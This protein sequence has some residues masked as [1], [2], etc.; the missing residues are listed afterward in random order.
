MA[1]KLLT[2]SVFSALAGL[3]LSY[4]SYAAVITSTK[5]G[6]GANSAERIHKLNSAWSYNWNMNKTEGL[7]D[8]V[9]YVPM[10]WGKWWPP[11]S[12]VVNS[13]EPEFILGF[14]EPDSAN[15][16]DTSVAVAIT[17]WPNIED[18]AE[19]YDL[20]ICSP[21]TTNYND[22]WMA[23]FMALA[24]DLNYQVDRLC[25]HWYKGPNAGT[26]MNQM[27]WFYNQYGQ[28]PIWL[29][30]F[31]VADWSGPNNYTQG[32]T[33]GFLAEALHRMEASNMIE[34]YAIFPW[35][36]TSTA[37]QASPIFHPNGNEL[38]AI[39]KLYAGFEADDIFGPYHNQI[40]YI[41]H[42]S[43]QRRMTA[44][45]NQVGA[46]NIFYENSDATFK[47]APGAN[48]NWLIENHNGTA[49]L[50][51]DG[52]NIHWTTNLAGTGTWVQ[53][54]LDEGANGWKFIES[55]GHNARL[56]Y[57]GNNFTMVASTATGNTAQWRFIRPD[58]DWQI[59][60]TDTFEGG[61]G[62]NWVDGGTDSMIY[63]GDRSPQGSRSVLLRDDTAS[64]VMT[65]SRMWLQNYSEVNVTFSYRTVSFD[66]S[67]EDFFLEMSLDGGG[68]WQ[69]IGSWNLTD[70]FV[71]NQLMHDGVTVHNTALTNNTKFR[72]RADASGDWDFLYIDNVIIAVR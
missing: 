56:N 29:T 38:T 55:V 34:R 43:T 44:T 27:T 3:L 24:E 51:Y 20:K 71:N 31:N 42:R 7:D 19:E 22:E 58:S 65:S 48:G 72:F 69:T 57:N 64:S 16:S 37:S 32:Q 36:G 5:K 50:R 21:A 30:E 15:Q 39:G 62:S 63:A 53:W 18:V 6:V 11:L 66:N 61:F 47:L 23:E 25:A 60:R 17:Q 4:T 9:E 45:N 49:R 33:Y 1:K 70:E 10:R 52:S 68:N 54:R 26:L 41:H 28:R 2:I 40:Y 14:N 59:L 13:G 12:N 67:N 46:Q 35:N 8:N